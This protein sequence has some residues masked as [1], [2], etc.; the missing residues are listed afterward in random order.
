MVYKEGR[1]SYGQCWIEGDGCTFWV[2]IMNGSTKHGP[3]S[4][5]SEAFND[6]YRYCC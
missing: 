6:F 4:S 2:Y 5:L 1:G 3:F